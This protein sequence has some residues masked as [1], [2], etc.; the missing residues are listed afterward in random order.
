MVN[1]LGGCMLLTHLLNSVSLSCHLHFNEPQASLR[2]FQRSKKPD[3]QPHK[4]RK[5]FIR[6]TRAKL[7]DV[8]TLTLVGVHHNQ[9]CLTQN[10]I[11]RVLNSFVEVKMKTVCPCQAKLALIIKKGSTPSLKKSCFL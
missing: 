10:H 11:P 3:W 5:V 1:E 6:R 7:L 8:L 9:C 2:T 4:R